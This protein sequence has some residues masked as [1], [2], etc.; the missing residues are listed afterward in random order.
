MNISSDH[1]SSVDTARYARNLM[2]EGFDISSQERLARASVAVVGAGALGSVVAM[3]LAGAGVGSLRIADFDS[4]SLSNLQRQIFFA[5]CEVGRPKCEVLC[6]KVMSLNSNTRVSP[7]PYAV[8]PDNVAD[9]IAGCDVVAVATDNLPSKA[10]VVDAAIRSSI[11][12]VVGGVREFQG[13]ISLFTPDSALSFSD[14]F[15]SDPAVRL[16]PPG[17]FG[18]VPGI[19]GAM[20]AAE[21]L[22]LLAGIGSPLRNTLL[23]FDVRDMNIRKFSF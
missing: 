17:V 15:P 20:Q 19:V 18:P 10:M 12:V 7:F 14:I 22:K 6:N 13:Q 4:I 21:I 2:L 16:S 11:P 3:Y 5:E 9:F 1:V 8:T 23:H